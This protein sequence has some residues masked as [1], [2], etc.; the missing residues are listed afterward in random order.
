MTHI[1][2]F[3]GQISSIVGKLKSLE[4][5]F[6]TMPDTTV[7]RL[8]DRGRATVKASFRKQLEQGYVQVLTPDG[9][10]FRAVPKRL[11]SRASARD[12]DA[13]ALKD[14]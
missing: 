4:N 6:M 11:K 14:V 10:L 7:E 1:S 2:A 13:E 8:D 9:V 3:R 12:V 5:P